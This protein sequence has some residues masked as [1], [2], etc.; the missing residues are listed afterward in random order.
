M[1]RLIALFAIILSLTLSSCVATATA[2]LNS[3]IDSKDGYQFLYPNGWQEVKVNNGPDVVFHDIIEQSENLSVIINPVES[4]KTLSDLGTPS[5]VGYKLSKTVIAPPNSGRT[6]ELVN[7]ESKEVGDKTYYLL[8][9]AVTL[10]TQKRH[11]L[12]SVVISRGKLLTF[13]VSATE[14]RW[15]KMQPVFE[16]V[17]NSFSAY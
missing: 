1:K 6:A 16:Q 14:A 5:E 4:E 17:I 3:Y 10:P 8:E 13:N 7:A 2:G 11:N 9:Y 12:A 15:Q